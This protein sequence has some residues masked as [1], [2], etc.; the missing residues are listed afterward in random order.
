[1]F[2]RCRIIRLARETNNGK[3][4]SLFASVSVM[5]KNN[6]RDKCYRT[7]NSHNFWMFLTG[8]SV[9]PGKPSLMLA[10]KAR[11]LPKWSTFQFLPLGNALGLTWIHQV[12]LERLPRDKHS[13]LLWTF[14]KYGRN[15]YI[16]FG[17]GIFYFTRKY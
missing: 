1:V 7:F 3:Q 11:S 4:A 2:H 13:G 6:I 15:F 9:Y 17:L 10:G 8:W 5:K 12:R 16:T 14:I